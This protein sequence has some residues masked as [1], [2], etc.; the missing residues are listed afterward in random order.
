MKYVYICSNHLRVLIEVEQQH[1]WKVRTPN[2]IIVNYCG[3][4]I[5]AL[6]KIEKKTD[7]PYYVFCGIIIHI[8][9]LDYLCWCVFYPHCGTCH[10]IKKLF[11]M[12]IR[13]HANLIYCRSLGQLRSVE[14]LQSAWPANWIKENGIETHNQWLGWAKE[15]K[16]L[17]E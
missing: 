9:W 3:F 12:R 16:M 2:W 13:T 14:K 1:R 11:E 7:N 6:E 8:P 15:K 10:P 5:F 17:L 4:S